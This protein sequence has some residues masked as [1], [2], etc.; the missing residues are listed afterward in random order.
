VN[1]IKQRRLKIITF[2][3]GG[4]SFDAQITSWQVQPGIKT[5]DRVYTFNSAGE[6]QNSFVEETDGE[7]TLNLKFLAD[8]TSG[9]IS[10]YLT[11]NSMATAAFVLDHHPD[12]VGEHVRWTGTVQLQAPDSGGDARATE[13]QE[14]T[15]P[16]LGAAPVYTRVG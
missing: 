9:G 8:W 16:I 11:A 4:T 13:M 3:I 2:T 15:L 1:A 10:D 5:G 7:P 12:I 14:V 6:G